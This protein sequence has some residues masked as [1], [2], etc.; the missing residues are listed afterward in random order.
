MINNT[1][2]YTAEEKI[3]ALY[4]RLSRDDE[5]QGDSNSIMNQKAILQKYADDNGFRNTS[6]FADDGYSG[7]NFERPDWKR[8]M[9][10]VNEGRV[11]TII[12]KDMSRLGRDYLKVGMYT[13]MVFPNA[14]VRF[15]AVNN[16][17]DSA[18]QID[19]DMTP[20]INIFNEFYA[21]D[22]SRKIR[23]VFKAKGE[24]GKPLASII[25][26]GYIKNPNDK[27]HW[28]ID[29]KAAEVVR[30]IFRLCVQGYGV[31][32]IVKI[33]TTRKILTPTAYAK[34][35][36]LI[37]YR[38]DVEGNKYVWSVRSV[39]NILSRIEYLGH[40]ANFKTY[41]KSYK[42]KKTILRDPS[43]WQIFKNTHEAIIDQETFDIVQR[44]RDGRRRK[45]LLGEMPILSGM[46]YCADCG[47]KLS[48]VRGQNWKHERE[49]MVCS[50]YR[51][52]GKQICPSH[53]V[54]NC[55]LEKILLS[56]LRSLTTFVREHEEDFLEM[57]MKQSKAEVEKSLRNEKKELDQ[58]QAR[59]SEIDTIIQKMYEDN[60]CGKISDERFI[61]LSNNYENEQKELK[62]RIKELERNI[63]AKQENQ[64]NADSFI[65]L[66]RSHTDIQELTP[67]IIREF[68]ERI[69]VCQTQKVGKR[70]VQ[71]IRII[72][73][74]IGEFAS[75]SKKCGNKK[76][77]H[78]QMTMLAKNP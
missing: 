13:E 55:A 43:D 54:H 27:T 23:A 57:V 15:I 76:H 17:V 41:R 3:T 61:K 70:K 69:E 78:A 73:N 1:Q 12:V 39:V 62:S 67:E 53:I 10:L 9:G 22:T 6:I 59:A 30:E 45:T 47:A 65:Q 46:V 68:V 18:N 8:L 21:K 25:P 33:L 7:T 20:F 5:L 29:E 64:V 31:T 38:K 49:Y 42:Q 28:I 44:I 40:T 24:S 16:G 60:V 71:R 37:A 75:P 26:Y 58:T 48:Q 66:V 34:E 56:G 19:N 4:C 36:G 52:K 72:W 14:N 77:S 32:Q 35:N 50:T 74:C 2:A 63:T 51:K 11:G